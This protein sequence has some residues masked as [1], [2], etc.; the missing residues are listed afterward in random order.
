MSP[1]IMSDMSGDIIYTRDQLT[2]G[3]ATG[4]G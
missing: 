3:G 1:N 2:G 4:G